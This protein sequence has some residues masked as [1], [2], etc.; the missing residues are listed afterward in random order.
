MNVARLMRDNFLTILL[1]LVL[2]FATFG[3]VL[4]TYQDWNSEV[5]AWYNAVST[6]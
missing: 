6:W 3:L 4:Q 2:A 1:S 5:S